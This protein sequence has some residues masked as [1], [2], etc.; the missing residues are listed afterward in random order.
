MKLQF[1]RLKKNIKIIFTKLYIIIS[2]IN[3]YKKNK[4]YNNV[5][6]MLIVLISYFIKINYFKL[7][8]INNKILT[9]I[10]IS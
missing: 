3:L 7:L 1:F 5:I 10:L 8:I 6:K 9:L 2:I 4:I